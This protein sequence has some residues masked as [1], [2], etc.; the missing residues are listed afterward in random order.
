MIEKNAQSLQ[1][2]ALAFV[3]DKTESSFNTLYYRLKPGLRKMILKYHTDP[4]TVAD[5]LAITLSKAYIYVDKYDSR[6]NFSTWVYKICQNECLMEIRRKNALYSLDHM[7]ESKMTVKPVREEDWAEIP[8]YEFFETHDELPAEKV[9]E[10]IMQ[11]IEALRS[12]YKEILH[13]REVKKMKYQEIA[14]V[15]HIN[16]NTVR[17]RIHNAKKI[18]KNRWLEKKR[19]ISDKPIYINNVGKIE[20]DQTL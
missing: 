20:F 2:I 11:E 13:D 5:I 9:Y 16:I 3:N 18:V 7:E 8:D 4:E 6:W 10:E 12:P 14:D 17:S 19:L 1:D 15:R